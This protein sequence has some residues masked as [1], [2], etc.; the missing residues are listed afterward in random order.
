MAHFDGIS[1]TV[2][3]KDDHT[4]GELKKKLAAAIPGVS[5]DGDLRFSIPYLMGSRFEADLN[6]TVDA[7]GPNTVRE[8][9]LKLQTA[10][11]G[12]SLDGDVRISVIQGDDQQPMHLH[13][14]CGDL[15]FG[16]R[17]FVR[18][19]GIEPPIHAIIGAA[20]TEKRSRHNS[21][22]KID[23]I[24]VRSTSSKD[25]DLEFTTIR[26]SCESHAY[27]KKEENYAGFILYGW[28]QNGNGKVLQDWWLNGKHCRNAYLVIQGTDSAGVK[29]MRR[30]GAP[31]QVHGAVYWNVFGEGAD[32]GHAV[33]EGFALVGKDQK[34]NSWT[35]NGQS[36]AYHDGKKKISVAAQE[37]VVKIMKDW[38][39]TSKVGKTYTVEQLLN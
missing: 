7:K 38:K 8:L 34:W 11:P 3:A 39:K 13:I 31:G 25:S 14:Q 27:N 32:P 33:G 30:K 29:E 37:C 12:L 24:V 5:L 20:N 26:L 16:C 4:I 35:F 18:S 19:P 28:R 1:Y 9:K 21:S 6:P 2:T 17:G 36:D 15:H 10:M 23:T 22:G